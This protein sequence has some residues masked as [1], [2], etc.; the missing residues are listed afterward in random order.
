M[1][2]SDFSHEAESKGFA[3]FLGIIGASAVV[4]M[5]ALGGYWSIEP[6][7]F[8]VVEEAKLRQEYDHIDDLPVGYVYANTLAH[9]AE[10]LLYKPGGYIT[11]DVGV[12]G[13]YLDN[14]TSWEYGALIMLRDATSA[15]RN[16]LARSQSQS[17]E[18]PDLANAEPYFYYEH[19]SWALPS[20]ESEYQKGI[21]SLHRYMVRLAD[22]NHKNPGHFYSRADNLWQYVEIVIKRLGGVSTQLSASTDRYEAYDIKLE[23]SAAISQTSWLMLD[24]VFW[25]ARGSCWALLHILKA[26]KHDFRAILE[27]KRAMETVNIMIHEMENALAEI[28]SPVILNGNGYGIFA[29]YSLAMASYVSRANAAALD[30]R[31]VMNRG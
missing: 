29:N 9:I 21:D 27:D 12:P 23:K 14:I 28:T 8:D 15:L 11:N 13:L 3:W 30:L 2:A 10:T 22:T 6:D 19:N 25:Q 5:I 7:A 1:S 31:D 16:H 26:I 20:S 4:V 24:N 18:D 17:A